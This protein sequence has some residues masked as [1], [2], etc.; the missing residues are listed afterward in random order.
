MPFSASS[1]VPPGAA[2]RNNSATSLQRFAPFRPSENKE[3]DMSRRFRTI[4]IIQLALYALGSGVPA[5]AQQPAQSGPARPNKWVG[6]WQGTLSAGQGVRLA[7]TIRQDS[8]GALNG[9][10]KNVDQA[11]VEANAVID[12]SGDTLRFTIAGEHITYLGVVNALGDSLRAAR[13]PREFRCR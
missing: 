10:M 6:T 9:L 11:G 8:T 5:G 12:V 1:A 7:L 4:L 2:C 13:S 3:Y